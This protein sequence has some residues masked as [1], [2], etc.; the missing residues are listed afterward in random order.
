MGRGKIIYPNINSQN[1]VFYYK[2]WAGPTSPGKVFDY[3]LN[4]N[5]GTLVG[6]DIHP[7][8]P[9][10]RFNGT[11]D[12]IDTG[13]PF[14]SV[15]RGSFTVHIWIK[16]DDGQ[17]LAGQFLCGSRD[18]VGDDSQWYIELRTNGT[19]R[20]YYESEGNAGTT[21]LTASSQFSD[22]LAPW[23][24]IACTADSTIGGPGAKKIFVNGTERT[25]SGTHDGNTTGVD[26]TE[27]TSSIN[28][29][30]GAFNKLAGPTDWYGGLIDETI[31]YNVAQSAQEIRS[32]FESTRWRYG[33]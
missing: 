8:Y 17:P 13:S 16:P 9:G 27:Y 33:V 30:I 4:D 3:S 23:T 20:F 25:L 32:I 31:I 12:Y 22:G 15:F 26:F 1:M 7:T 11:D 18:E 28:I 14:Q 2:L 5:L 10:F 29:A 21:A 6:T 24:H 19:I